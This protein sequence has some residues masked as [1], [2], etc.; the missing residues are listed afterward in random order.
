MTNIYEAY[1]ELKP[2]DLKKIR[3]MFFAE[4]KVAESTLQNFL[5]GIAQPK[6]KYV[7]FFSILFDLK[8]NLSP[9]VMAEKLTK[10]YRPFEYKEYKNE[11]KKSADKI[12]KKKENNNATK[13]VAQPKNSLRQQAKENQHQARKARL[14]QRQKQAEFDAQYR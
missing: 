4:F 5:Q 8:E 14:E 12:F 9:I 2:A 11:A 7:K 3:Y 1:L 6:N 13:N 10:E